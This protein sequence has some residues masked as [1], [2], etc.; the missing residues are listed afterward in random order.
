MSCN[1]VF[2]LCH[3]E[4]QGCGEATHTGF[5]T[6]AV[7]VPLCSAAQ[8]RHHHQRH[9]VVS[10]QPPGAAQIY[11]PAHVAVSTLYRQIRRGPCRAFALAPC[12][13][14]VHAAAAPAASRAGYIHPALHQ[15]GLSPTQLLHGLGARTH[16]GRR[17]AV[18]SRPLQLASNTASTIKM[19]QSTQTRCRIFSGA[20][21]VGLSLV[22]VVAMGGHSRHPRSHVLSLMILPLVTHA[23]WAR[24]HPSRATTLITPVALPLGCSAGLTMH[25][26]SANWECRVPQS[27]AQHVY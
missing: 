1:F 18:V 16:Q 26:I 10:N 8:T 19:L 3:I 7:R 17:C 2:M 9:T 21:G 13:W 6:Q 5:C 15:Q 22:R 24:Q 20:R 23:L 11:T 14:R 25:R 12:R 27:A 4:S